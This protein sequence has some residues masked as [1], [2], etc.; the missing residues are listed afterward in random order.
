MLLVSLLYF[1]LPKWQKLEQGQP[2]VQRPSNSPPQINTSP[3]NQPDTNTS[4][5]NR[6]SSFTSSQAQSSS[7]S[8]STSSAPK[9]SSPSTLPSSSDSSYPGSGSGT[10]STSHSGGSN[11]QSSTVP[12]SSSSGYAADDSQTPSQEQRELSSPQS[13]SQGMSKSSQS[14]SGCGVT[15]GGV[16]EVESS[17]REHNSPVNDGRLSARDVDGDKSAS[18]LGD[19]DDN[20]LTLE[21]QS[22]KVID[23][24]QSQSQSVVECDSFQKSNKP[25]ATLLKPKES[26]DILRTSADILRTSTDDVGKNLAKADADVAI[27]SPLTLEE[28]RGGS[29]EAEDRGGSLEAEDRGGSLEAE[30][31]GGSLEAEE[32]MDVDSATQNS[33]CLQ[34]SPSQS[35]P[36]QD[37][38]S[39]NC[40]VPN[41][42]SLKDEV[43]KGLSVDESKIDSIDHGSS[44]ESTSVTLSDA[45]P[46]V[47]GAVKSQEPLY[48]SLTME[49]MSESLLSSGKS[50]AEK[51]VS[52]QP[53]QRTQKEPTP[54]P[55]PT[56]TGIA[57][58]VLYIRYRFSS[59]C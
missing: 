47:E 58:C 8:S 59:V 4:L 32:P 45:S 38:G 37:S 9:S 50:E 44:V 12:S 35:H 17:T 48:E 26:P 20:T 21:V 31:R 51:T 3:S 46:L 36:T 6:D 15:K 30:D 11:Q 49:A 41:S 42:T 52:P 23:L 55:T 19:D 10:T 40:S 34:L 27:I 1:Q 16:G 29:L 5:K 53:E 57:G 18:L 33:F 25:V 7:G 13:P 54:L 28:D 43:A 14:G 22:P 24:T 56:P 39:K 2:S